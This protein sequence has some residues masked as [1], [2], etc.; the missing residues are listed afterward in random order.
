MGIKKY[1]K[2][3][4]VAVA[5]EGINTQTYFASEALAQEYLDAA[6]KRNKE[7][8]AEWAVRAVKRTGCS[9]RSS[10]LP[11][12]W[13][14]YESIRSQ[15]N[16]SI[17]SSQILSCSF[18]KDRERIVLRCTYGKTYTRDEAIKMLTKKVL[19]R[20]KTKEKK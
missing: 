14:D 19:A 5:V 4:R 3:F 7:N 12:G 13:S 17:V 20:L 8:S 10:D 16:G 2:K 6:R 11:V 1:H 9:K 15:P 18:L